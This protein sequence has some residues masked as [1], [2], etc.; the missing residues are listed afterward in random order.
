MPIAYVLVAMT[1]LL[2]GWH[3]SHHVSQ[4]REVVTESEAKVIAANM[5]AYKNMLL[6]VAMFR[7]VNLGSMPYYDRFMTET[8]RAE[9]F[10]QNTVADQNIILRMPN[11]FPGVSAYID[12]GRVIVYYDGKNKTNVQAELLKMSGGSYNVGR[13]I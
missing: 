1:L 7:D 13:V 9:I 8:E 12:R 2:G 10:L 11:K 6:E 5:L 3:Q 4:A